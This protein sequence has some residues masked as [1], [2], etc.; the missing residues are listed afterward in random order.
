MRKTWAI[1]V[2]LVIALIFPTG[3]YA[4]CFDQAAARYRIPSSLL[5]AISRVESSG[6]PHA[7]HR[8]PDGS[9]DIGHMQ[10]NSRWIPVLQRYG[11]TERN[12]FDACTN[13][14]VGAWILA[15]NIHQLGYNWNA[16]G[17]YNASSN[18]K[19]MAYA[20]KIAAILKREGNL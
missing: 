13:T 12:L 9:Y 19:R 5:M 8:N 3:G 17:A 16:I 1:F 6:N 2:S 7:I 4:A 10:I 20:R 15:Q 18:T 14:Y 11:I